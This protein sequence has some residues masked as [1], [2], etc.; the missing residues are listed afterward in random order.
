MLA[1]ISLSYK[2]IKDQNH[3]GQ[4]RLKLWVSEVQAMDEN[5][6]LYAR[7]IPVPDQPEDS[8]DN[9]L[10]VCT[11]A[12]LEEFQAGEPYEGESLWRDSSVD[13]AFR[14]WQAM[15]EMLAAIKSTTQ[16]LVDGVNALAAIDYEQ[17]NTWTYLPENF[18][19]ISSSSSS[20][21]S[22]SSN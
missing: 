14:T 19:S 11:P 13:M 9:Y 2:V 16:M 6:F 15:E 17:P 1:A 8:V 18:S 5:I 4:C 20:S 7:N 12:D 22:G 21:S 10:N 3:D